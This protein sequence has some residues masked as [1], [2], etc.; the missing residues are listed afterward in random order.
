MNRK[1]VV[2]EDID[3]LIIEAGGQKAILDAGL[4]SIYGVS[5]KALNLADDSANDR[6]LAFQPID[7]QLCSTVELRKFVG[8]NDRPRSSHKVKQMVLD[9]L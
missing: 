3:S 4:A 1:K 2:A 5:T 9:D 6:Q 8:S 7:Y